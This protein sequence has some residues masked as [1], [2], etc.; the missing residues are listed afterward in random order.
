MKTSEFYKLTAT[1]I[2][3]AFVFTTSIGAQSGSLKNITNNKYALANLISGI[4][5]D[6]P[7]LRRSAIYFAGKY[8]V[9][10]TVDTLIDLI[11]QENSPEMRSLIALV[12]YKIGSEEGLESVKY[13]SENDPDKKVRKMSS[14]I[15]DTYLFET[16]QKDEIVQND[17]INK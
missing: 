2:L 13:L 16:A 10:E 11:D 3:A 17:K 5:S 6:N 12:L 9:K 1:I 14:A 8:K 15:Y 7:G 4:N